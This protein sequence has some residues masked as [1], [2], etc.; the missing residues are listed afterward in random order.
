V[1]VLHVTPAHFDASSVVGGAE[2]YVW[3]LARAMAEQVETTFFALAARPGDRREGPLRVI[4]AVGRPII[5]HALARNPWSRRL[6]RAIRDADVVHCFQ[7][8]TFLTSAAM[9]IARALGRP[10][11]VTDLGGGHPYSPAHYVPLLRWAKAFLLISEYS[12]ALW[13]SAPRYSHPDRLE[14]VYA[15]VDVNRFSPGEPLA[16]PTEVLFVGRVLPH[17]GVEHLIDA[18]EPPFSL[19]V[20]GQPYDAAYL[21]MLQARAHGRAVVF[22]SDVDDEGL[23]QRYRSAL[24]LVA[25]SVSTDWQGRTTSISELFGL[26]AAEAMACGRPA[27]VSDTGSLP[28]VVADGV[29][30]FVVPSANAPAIRRRLLE[31]YDDPSRANEMGQR[32]RQRVLERFTWPATAGRCIDVYRTSVAT[33]A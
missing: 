15:G 14:V 18:I 1:R 29:T 10:V 20:V 22:E 13:Q 31:L 28:E 7:A 30:G 2:R 17:K 6:V 9:V 33:P 16:R 3:E 5:E 32:A 19:R 11:F 27:I 21:S 12:R 25:P 26:V 23:A 24:A 8:Q 4:H